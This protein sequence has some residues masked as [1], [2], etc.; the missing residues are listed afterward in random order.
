MK[1]KEDGFSRF[2]C[3]SQAKRYRATPDPMK[4]RWIGGT[5]ADGKDKHR[6][7]SRRKNLWQP[8]QYANATINLVV[9]NSAKFDENTE[10]T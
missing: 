9:K 3:Y 8:D 4:S 1:A 2:Q 5:I 6:D 7:T 10:A